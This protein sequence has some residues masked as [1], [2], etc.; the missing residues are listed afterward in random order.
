MAGGPQ[1]KGTN[2]QLSARYSSKGGIG[3]VSPTLTDTMVKLLLQFSIMALL[4][5]LKVGGTAG[6][7][8]S[9][10]SIRVQQRVD[11]PQHTLTPVCLPFNRWLQSRWE[12]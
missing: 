1:W 8:Q 4:K 2:A 5:V 7:K 12:D 9:G 3:L 10:V 11:K 6:P